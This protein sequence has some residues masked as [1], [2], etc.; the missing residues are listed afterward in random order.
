MINKI[1]YGLAQKVFQVKLENLRIL[2]VLLKMEV[3]LYVLVLMIL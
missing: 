2:K 1:L 3:I